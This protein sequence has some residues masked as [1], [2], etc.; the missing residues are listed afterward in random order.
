ME[1]IKQKALKYEYPML[2][3]YQYCYKLFSIVPSEIYIGKEIE[4]EW[5]TTDLEV[6]I[7]DQLYLQSEL[8]EWNAS[9]NIKH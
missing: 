9:K 6:I 4:E 1:A 8:L 3:V 7:K 5:T 2:R